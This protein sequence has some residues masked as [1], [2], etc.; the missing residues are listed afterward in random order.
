MADWSGTV[1]SSTANYSGLNIPQIVN[2]L[3]QAESAPLT[4][5]QNKVSTDNAE[6]SAYGS[7]VSSLSSLNT[8]A[9]NMAVPTIYG[10]AATSSNSSVLTGTADSSAASGNYSIT[11]SHLA[12]AQSVYSASF[13]SADTTAVANTGDV[14]FSI[15]AGSGTAADINY[16][17]TNNDFYIGSNTSVTYANSLNGVS[18]AINAAGAGVTSSVINTGSGYQLVLTSASSGAAN[19]M[20]VLVEPSGSSAYG[21]STGTSGINQLAF[22]PSSYNTDGSVPATGYGTYTNMQQSMAGVDANLTLNGLSV[23]R[24]SNTIKDLITGVTLDLQGT[25]STA[26]N[27]AVANDNTGFTTQINSFITTYNSVMGTINKALGNQSSPGALYND[28]LTEGL[29]N[30]LYDMTTTAYNGTSL[31]A[32]GITH[33]STGNLALDSTTWNAAL[34]ANPGQVL[35]A[36]NQMATSLQST[37]NDYMN[38]LVPNAESGLQSE[39]SLYQQQEDQQQTEMDTL[40]QMYTQEFQSMEQ[41]LGTL[42]NQ[43]SEMS[44]IVNGTSS[45]SSSSGTSSGSSSGG[46]TA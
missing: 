30:N 4:D 34:A 29:N 24:S 37:M 42:Q 16:D 27:L 12:Q 26:V 19:R 18:A 8:L 25:S 2:A 3:V 45:S 46:T 39:I 23:T 5:L 22:D 33:D 43:G 14:G 1:T 15:Q 13:A 40:R 6:I 35:G 44:S 32:M 38:N 10:M 41:Y 9:S 7:L 17:S 28:N 21:D 20:K 36:I 31:A 11:V